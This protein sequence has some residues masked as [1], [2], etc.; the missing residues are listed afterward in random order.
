MDSLKY[1]VESKMHGYYLVLFGMMGLKE[2]QVA[3]LEASDDDDLDAV[4]GAWGFPADFRLKYLVE[5]ANTLAK[6]QELVNKVRTLGDEPYPVS[7]C[8]IGHVR[9]CLAMLA[10]S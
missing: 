3:L 8:E 10:T 5:D 9:E 7:G 2:V 6:T 1:I 4:L